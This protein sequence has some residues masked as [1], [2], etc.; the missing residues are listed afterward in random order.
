M[1][2][3]N[4][5][6]Q[7]DIIKRFIHTVEQNRISHAQLLAGD[8]GTGKLQLAIAY[9]QYISCKQR[10]ATDSCGECSSCKKYEKLIH[11]DLHFVFPVARTKKFDKPVSDNFIAEWRDFILNDKKY[12]L[13]AWLEKIGSENAQAGIFAHES[14]SII[15]K[16]SLKSFESDYKIMII[17]LPEKMNSSAANKLLKLIEE[18]PSKTLFLLVAEYPEQI[19]NTIRSRSQ[20]IKIPK[21]DRQSVADYLVKEYDLE[22]NQ[23]LNYAKIS[24]GNLFTAIDQISLSE[25]EQYNF[26]MYVQLMRLCYSKKI[27]EITKWVD[28]I[29]KHN[30]ERQKNFLTYAMRLFRENYIMN[31]SDNKD[32]NQLNETEYSFSTKF[33]TFI[34]QNNITG[35]SKEL[36]LAYKHISRNGTGKII[37]LDMALKLVKLLHVKKD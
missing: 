2:F 29:C 19:I 37:F 7:Q 16:L 10:S 11:P 14:N 22:Q 32:L 30:R 21:I 25:L 12:R 28:E 4:I 34:H 8:E 36:N 15:K 9:A 33:Y 31:I 23:A 18:P 24:G 27:I 5:I 3:K 20:L 1:R 13:N 26:D 35:I 6:G 17:W